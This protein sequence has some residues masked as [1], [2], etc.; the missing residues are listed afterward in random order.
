[1]M[2]L[3]NSEGEA[4]NYF[5]LNVANRANKEFTMTNINENYYGLRTTLRSAFR[6]NDYIY[7]TN[8]GEIIFAGKNSK[9]ANKS[10]IYE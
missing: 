10:N 1:M 9:Y 6:D 2:Q 7:K 5:T 3:F 8:T 4:I